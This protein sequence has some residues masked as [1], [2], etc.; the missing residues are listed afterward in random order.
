MTETKPVSFSVDKDSSF[1]GLAD[2]CGAEQAFEHYEEL[3]ALDEPLKISFI[4]SPVEC[5]LKSI[6][7]ELEGL[8]VGLVVNTEQY[9]RYKIAAHK[10]AVDARLKKSGFKSYGGFG[11]C[12]SSGKKGMFIHNY[13]YFRIGGETLEVRLL[14]DNTVKGKRRLF[15]D[16]YKS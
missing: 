2:L 6:L 5:K 8:P 1:M 4:H 13:G 14:R 3:K 16:V 11:S 10:N 7:K 9:A 15:L 12:D